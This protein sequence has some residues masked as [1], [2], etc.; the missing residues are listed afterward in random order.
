MSTVH[1]AYN[2]SLCW[3][4][5]YIPGPEISHLVDVTTGVVILRV[6]PAIVPVCCSVDVPPTVLTHDSVHD[7]FFPQMEH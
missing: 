1:R 6:H 3:L 5:N 2:A 7:S 4:R